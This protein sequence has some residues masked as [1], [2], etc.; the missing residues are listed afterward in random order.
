MGEEF[1][2]TRGM[3][4]SLRD[5]VFSGQLPAQELSAIGFAPLASDSFVWDAEDVRETLSMTGKVQEQFSGA[6]ECLARGRNVQLSA[7][8]E[9]D[10]MKQEDCN[11]DRANRD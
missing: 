9:S 2:I 7:W 3:P 4:L 11:E 10:M 5:V 1:L 6:S 8:G